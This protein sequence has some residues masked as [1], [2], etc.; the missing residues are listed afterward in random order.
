M[1][2]VTFAVLYE[3]ERGIASTNAALGCHVSTSTCCECGLHLAT[4]WRTTNHSQ[5]SRTVAGSESLLS[6]TLENVLAQLTSI[7]DRIARIEDAVAAVTVRTIEAELGP[8]SSADGPGQAVPV[9]AAPAT[10]S[11]L[12]GSFLNWYLH[13]I[14]ETVKGKKR[15]E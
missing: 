12:T 2:N 6:S 14:W 3:L 10:A 7:N 9:V 5:L 15:A 1:A 8:G 4:R 13:R 11:T